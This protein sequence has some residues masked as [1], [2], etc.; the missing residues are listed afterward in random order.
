MIIQEN[1]KKKKKNFDDTFNV[2]TMLSISFYSTKKCNK[3]YK[4]CHTICLLFVTQ[5][6]PWSEGKI[7]CVVVVVFFP[8]SLDFFHLSLLPKQEMMKIKSFGIVLYMSSFSKF[9]WWC[10][11]FLLENTIGI[12]VLFMRYNLFLPFHLIEI[13]RMDRLVLCVCV[14][15]AYHKKKANWNSQIELG[16]CEMVVF[17]I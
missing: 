6:H 17:G 14:W 3:K 10:V 2:L 15:S 4:Y 13:C 11:L 5:K 8:R 1:K 9:I 16:V 12:F 7:C